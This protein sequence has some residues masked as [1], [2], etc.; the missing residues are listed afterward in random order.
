MVCSHCIPGNKF[1]E[2][3]RHHSATAPQTFPKQVLGGGGSWEPSPMFPGNAE[4]RRDFEKEFGSS[5]ES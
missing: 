2:T 1:L 5:S 4:R 3:E